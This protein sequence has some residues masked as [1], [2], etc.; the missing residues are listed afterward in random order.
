M[1]TYYEG[2][3]MLYPWAKIA[4]TANAEHGVPQPPCIKVLTTDAGHC[5]S[6]TFRGILI[7]VSMYDANRCVIHAH[8]ARGLN[9]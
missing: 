6:A 1:L 8:V 5:T 3:V 2:V 4:A 7:T 9:A